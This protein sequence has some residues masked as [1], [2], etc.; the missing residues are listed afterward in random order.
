V[1]AF[2]E[3]I[4]IK[5]RREIDLMRVAARHVGEIL[6]ELR[7]LARPGITTGELDEHARGAI[8][9]RGVTSS[10]LGYGPHGLPRYPAVL[11]VSVN[12]EVVHGIPGER[13]L[14]EGDLLSL[15][16]GVIHDG[17]HGDSA[18]TVPIGTVSS[19]VRRLLDA[20]R[21]SLERGIEQMRPGRRLSDIGHAVQVR[22]E[23]EGFSVVRQ[24]VGHGIGRELHE[25]PQIPNYGPGGRGPRLKPGMVFAIEPMVTAGGA[26]VRILD[27][28]WTAVTADGSLAAHFEHTIL[29]TEEGPEVLTRVPGSH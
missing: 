1:M 21:E 17:Y 8:R 11:C 22:A 18:V 13:E 29:I 23:S 7:E 9:K 3:A 27:D 14:K 4:R 26:E 19:E 20:T 24:F 6:L 25:P 10:F 5:T 12:E 16:F 2:G 28:Q 15:D